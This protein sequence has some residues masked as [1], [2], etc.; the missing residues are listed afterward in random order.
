MRL[1]RWLWW[2]TLLAVAVP[3]ILLGL[4]SAPI[5]STVASVTVV[6]VL[7]GLVLLGSDLSW[8]DWT[9]TAAGVV[10]VVAAAPVLGR[11]TPY[12]LLLATA[13]SPPVA[14][15]LLP[16]TRKRWGDAAVDAAS[17]ATA[18]VRSCWSVM[19]GAELCEMWSRSFVEVKSAAGV[20][21]RAVGAALRA[22]VLDELERRDRARLAAWL[23]RHP[24]PA[25]TPM[26]AWTDRQRPRA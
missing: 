23:A 22:D 12:L 16:R 17:D 3:A 21:E 25:S 6:G 24:S 10:L 20:T 13:S 5:A 4:V 7:A 2:T 15:L 19:T 8:R 11:A 14:R 26:W 9:D 18:D 1:Y